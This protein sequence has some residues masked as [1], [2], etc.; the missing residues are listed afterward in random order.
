MNTLNF[1]LTYDIDKKIYCFSTPKTIDLID[2]RKANEKESI[3][4]FELNSLEEC[5]FLMTL[6]HN[7]S[8]SLS[9]PYVIK[10]KS[11]VLVSS[12]SQEVMKFIEK[13]SYS[14]FIELVNDIKS[15]KS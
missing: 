15:R 8:I 11:V 10:I 14:D 1:F 9:F 2:L 3:L 12:D 5:S 6:L 7:G 13:I 4:K